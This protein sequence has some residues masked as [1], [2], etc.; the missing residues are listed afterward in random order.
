MN[1][2]GEMFIKGK[3][4]SIG[5]FNTIGKDVKVGNNVRIGH[6]CII[7]DNVIIGNDIIIQG[8]IKIASDTIIEDG[9]TF[10]HG[11]IITNGVH[12]KKNVF[13]GPNSITLGGTHER[14]TDWGT[15]IGENCYIGAGAL[16]T[17]AVKLCDDV[18]LG[19]LTF[20]TKDIEVPGTYIGIPAKLIKEK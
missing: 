11:T 7:E 17:A 6:N 14:K 1:E 3:N 8:N 5:N 20:V 16:I 15:V 2:I 4:F 12:I 9:C 19:A 10:K 13:F 18:I